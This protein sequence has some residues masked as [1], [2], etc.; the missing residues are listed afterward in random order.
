M[1]GELRSVGERIIEKALSI[2]FDEAAVLLHYREASM[3][4]YANSEPSVIQGWRERS[5]NIYVAKDRRILFTGGSVQSLEDITG[6]LEQ[7]RK[8]A[9]KVSESMLY[10]P[11]PGPSEVKPL[12]GLV[13]PKVIDLVYDLSPASEALFE[14]ANR[15][16][17]DS[18]AG[19]FEAAHEYRVVM[20][21]TGV[22]LAEEGTSI[23]TYIRAFAGEGSGQWSM[24]SRSYD[25]EKV[26]RVAET[27][28]HYA[29]L[30]RHQED[31][32][33]GEYNIV[34][35]PMVV[36]DLFNY[37]VRMASAASVL[38]GTS[39]FVGKKPGEKIASDAVTIYDDAREAG[40]PGSRSF[41][42]EG[43]PTRRNPIIE[44]GVFKTLLHNTKTAAKMG[45]ESTGNAGLLMP[46]AWNIIVE[47]GNY[48]FDELVEEA[49][50][51]FLVTNNWYTRL[52]NHVEG[53]FSTITRDAV[54]IIRDGE[55]AGAARKFRI[56]DSFPRLLKNIAALGSE[57]Y[58]I[59]WWEVRVPTR[60]P[61]I[62]A[63]GVKTSKH[64]G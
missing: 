16:H 2:G 6:M 43:V 26:E 30:S 63:R 32:E 4:K 56:A 59:Y 19:M 21:S 64:T 55:I 24:G 17:I 27:A 10:A 40:L 15:E 9:P 12:H 33:P 34:L 39:M 31:V 29:V 7:L 53:I 1:I 44:K 54:L 20:T 28:A 57:V 48:S 38:M 23:E 18:F 42:D 45:T 51:G 50:N 52:Q 41:D 3:A 22:D 61:Y 37:I 11:L 62:L 25:R 8:V 49:G 46:R 36:G 13:D 47:P 14:A 60:T 58:D 5:V 35:S